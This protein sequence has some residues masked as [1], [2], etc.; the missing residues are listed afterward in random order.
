VGG[1]RGVLVL[2]ATG[3]WESTAGEGTSPRITWRVPDFPVIAVLA[4]LSV[5]LAIAGWSSQG[6]PAIPLALRFLIGVI[7]FGI[8]PGFLIVGPW[9][10]A[11]GRRNLG[12]ADFIV[13]VFTCSFSCNLVFN[14]LLFILKMSFRTLA[15]NY[16]LLQLCGYAAWAIRVVDPAEAGITGIVKI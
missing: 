6:W 11:R 3:L 4:P 9:V 13:S 1:I 15:W 16:L 5:V 2:L 7:A 10:A 8:S 12:P 14:V